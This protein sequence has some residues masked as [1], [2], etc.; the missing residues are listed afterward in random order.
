MIHL[1]II[2]IKRS[3]STTSIHLKGKMTV[4]AKIWDMPRMIGMKVQ[5]LLTPIILCRW[6][7]TPVIRR[8]PTKLATMTMMPSHKVISIRDSLNKKAPYCTS[9]T[10][11]TTPTSMTSW[12]SWRPKVSIQREQSSYMTNRANPKAPALFK[13]RRSMKP[14]LQSRHCRTNP[15][16]EGT[17]LWTWLQ[18]KNTDEAL[19]QSNPDL[20]FQ[21]LYKLIKTAPSIRDCNLY[22]NTPRFQSLAKNIQDFDMI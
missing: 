20:P 11:A 9:Q 14:K 8:M 18:I 7:P 17:W 21:N 2:I 22:M 13:W 15:S 6:N 5:A 19:V 1:F 16:K 4:K 12:R 3:P 10:W